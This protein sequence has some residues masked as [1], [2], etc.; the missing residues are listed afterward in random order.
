[1]T[2]DEVLK[3]NNGRKFSTTNSKIKYYF[4]EA[5]SA[6]LN[7]KTFY[8]TPKE[9]FDKYGFLLDTSN[10]NPNIP[11]F[12]RVADSIFEYVGFH[13][14]PENILLAHGDFAWRD[15]PKEI[16]YHYNR[17]RLMGEEGEVI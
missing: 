6:R 5:P 1:M 15:M 17:K 2:L 9:Y 10:F 11:D 7:I 12:Q 14:K 3:N 8:I 4:C 13:G 16:T